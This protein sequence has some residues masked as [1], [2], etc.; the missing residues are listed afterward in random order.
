M[1]NTDPLLP[2]GLD[3]DKEL[4]DRAVE[5]RVLTKTAQA[6]VDISPEA[7]RAVR[8]AARMLLR[9]QEKAVR[10]ALRAK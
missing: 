10:T 8:D 3:S 1:T 9:E 4:H 6:I 2:H 5:I 7:A